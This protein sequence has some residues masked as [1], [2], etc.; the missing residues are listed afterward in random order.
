MQSLHPEKA[1]ARCDLGGSAGFQNQNEHSNSRGSIMNIAT[2]NND[3]NGLVTQDLKTTSRLIAEKFEKRHDHVLRDIRVLV[4]TNP[5]W[6][7][8]NFGETPYVEATN[9]QTYQMYE[10][11][12]DGYSMLVMGFTGK[13]AMEWK[14]KFLEA[15]NAMEAQLK[16][17]APVLDLNDPS[18]L[19]GLLGSYA[20]RTE[21]AEAKVLAF[22]PKAIALDRLDAAEGSYTPRPAS[23]ILGVGEQKLIKWL[24]ANNWAF[25]QSGKGPLQAYSDKRN[26]G[27]LDHK[28]HS[29]EDSKTEETKTSI[30][31]LI[32]PKGMARLA[33]IFAKGGVV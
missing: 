26:V 7:S 4:A 31:M 6:G 10:M 23:K 13:K 21:V 1:K 27:Y 18:Q 12:R 5:E 29:Y 19:R 17:A 11:T 2:S 33:T 3:F 14:I 30:Q 8:P 16:T 24:Q 28:L 9:G 22:E 32:T 25:R 15:F 20:E